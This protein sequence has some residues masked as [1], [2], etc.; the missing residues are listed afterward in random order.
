[1]TDGTIRLATR[2][3]VDEIFQL[4]RDL[5]DYERGLDQVR[6]T[7]DA[8]ASLLFG[9]DDPTI[10]SVTHHGHPA[11]WCHV[12]E[13]ADGERQLGGFALW[14]LNTSTWTGKHGI[15]LEDLFVRPEVRGRGY[16]QVL[17]STLAAECVQ[18]DYARLEWWVLDWNSPAIDFYLAQGAEA[19][20]E[21]T[22][23]RVSG[24]ELPRLAG[25]RFSE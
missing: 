25:T 8:L 15:Y 21:W 12:V 6:I 16:G 7:P 23:Y 24:D 11:A 9:G 1:M 2:D 14:F 22:V 17:L 4:I 3:D 18:N 13:H 19:M 10:A 5:A 20:D